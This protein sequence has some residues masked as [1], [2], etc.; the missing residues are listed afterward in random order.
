MNEMARDSIGEMALEGLKRGMSYGQYVAARYYPVRIHQVQADGSTIL[1]S[2]AV[3]EVLPGWE[4]TVARRRSRCVDGKGRR[5]R[6]KKPEPQ[7]AEKAATGRKCAVCGAE[8]GSGQRL[9]CGEVCKKKASSQR[10][11]QRK[12]AGLVKLPPRVE[13]VTRECGVCGK[14]FETAM[15]MQKYCGAECSK[16]AQYAG[17]KL[18]WLAEL[19][20][21]PKKH[22]IACGV[23]LE[24]RAQKYCPT[25]AKA[26]RAR[27]QRERNRK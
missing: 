2:A 23:E 14:S 17:N 26:E 25:C 9:Y 16:R 19:E 20:Q 8:L 7:Q 11:Y 27:Y 4:E 1:R 15:P 22:R 18:R 21:R 5:R 13:R 10:Y 6:A 24:G 12:K 3:P